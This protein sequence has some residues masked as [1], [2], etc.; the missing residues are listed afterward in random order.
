MVQ[1]SLVVLYLGWAVAA[2]AAGPA[3][4]QWPLEIK[5]ALSSTFGETRKASFHAG[6][7][8]KTWGR[9]G[10]AVKAIADGYVWR[11]RTSRA[12]HPASVSTS[13]GW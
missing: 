5:P 1:W 3:Q 7:D 11:L 10:Y 6:M 9:T 13:R 12:T 4:W 8:V 2:A